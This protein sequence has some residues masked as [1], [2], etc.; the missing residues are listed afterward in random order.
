MGGA[1]QKTVSRKKSNTRFARGHSVR[2][3]YHLYVIPETVLPQMSS[4][5]TDGK[6]RPSDPVDQLNSNSTQFIDV[7][8]L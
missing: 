6:G 4:N 8:Q 7:W 3:G 2:Q 1:D 5:S